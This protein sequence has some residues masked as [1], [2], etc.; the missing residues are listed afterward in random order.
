MQDLLNLVALVC[1]ALASMGFGVYT[2]YA[3]VK[4]AFALMHWHAQQSAPAKL[5]PITEPARVS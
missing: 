2:A 4:A 3:L 5:K 1:A